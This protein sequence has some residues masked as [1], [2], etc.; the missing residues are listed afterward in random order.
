MARRLPLIVAAAALLA[1]GQASGAARG[2]GFGTATG[3]VSST[4][5][6]LWARADRGGA[7]SLR[8]TRCGRRSG[9]RRALRAR[10][11]HDFTVQAVV[12]RL[13][14]GTA[15]CYRF[16]MRGGRRS[17]IGRFV[18]APG[19]DD[20]RTVRFAYSGDA[21]AQPAPG[22]RRPFYDDFGVY[23]RMLAERNDFNVNL[24]NTIYSDSEVPGGGRFD[25]LS[26][27][28][29]WAKYRQNL[30]L[31]QLSRL[32]TSG[33]L[34][35]HWDDHEFYNN[36]SP[37]ER[38]FDA[39]TGKDKRVIAIDPLALYRAGSAA[40]R[41]YTPV[42]YSSDLGLYRHFRWGRNLEL[43]FLD[44]RSFRSA[45][46]S[47]GHACDNPQTGEPDLAPTT[48]GTLARLEFGLV[49]SPLRRPVSP[50]CLDTIRDPRRT[51]LGQRQYERF[52]QDV[53]RST[54]T[55]KVIMSEVP[56]QQFY[57]FP[58]DRWEGYEAE[59]RRLLRFL[60][61]NVK[62]AVFLTTD[63]RADLVNEARLSTLEPGGPV[64]SGIL[65]VTTGPVAAMSYERQLNGT[66]GNDLAGT[67]MQGLLL[68]PSPPQGVGMRCAAIDSLSFGEVEVTGRTLTVALKD[69]RGDPVR[70]R[71]GSG[72]ACGEVTLTAR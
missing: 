55:F 36:F 52:T 31:P 61:D 56:I 57:I 59:R 40:F 63:V 58:Y 7:V 51:M 28:Q 37:F 12:R 46:A 67:A 64:G 20:A 68:K 32:R 4:S 65:E 3:E 1:P 39:A 14:P 6:R 47:A 72:K 26:L 9:I 29:K 8:V 49:I 35:G 27:E 53:K 13:R 69:Q 25:A 43:F 70:E 15:Y 48:Q 38:D 54:A 5:A 60:R 42:S 45:K 22:S 50:R 41:D 71:P 16:R 62:N 10:R 11:S 44:E 34:Y 66:V 19:P 24:G 17:E 23:G 21:D 2:F 30:A 33:P 18:T